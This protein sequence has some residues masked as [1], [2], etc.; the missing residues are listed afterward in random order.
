MKRAL[1]GLTL[2]FG[3]SACTL[4]HEAGASVAPADDSDQV[5]TPRSAA[6]KRGDDL[7]IPATPPGAVRVVDEPLRPIEGAPTGRVWLLEMYQTVLSEKDELVRRSADTTRERDAAIAR[8]AELEKARADLEAR[9]SGLAT[10]L[11]ELQTKTLEIAR[12]LAES[13]LARLKAEKAALEGRT[14][15]A[16]GDKP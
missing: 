15:V 16:S 2:C 9:S 13:E 11:R 8:V 10:E 1:L 14:I 7:A 4:L 5:W 3:L 6:P 12:R